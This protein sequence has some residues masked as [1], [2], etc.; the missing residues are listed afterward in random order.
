[1]V[2][3]RSGV[4]GSV[5]PPVPYFDS[6]PANDPFFAALTRSARLNTYAAAVTGASVALEAVARMKRWTRKSS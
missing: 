5:P 6:A 1:M 3:C 4:R 2:L